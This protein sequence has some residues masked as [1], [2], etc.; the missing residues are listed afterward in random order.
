MTQGY[1][2]NN[3][4]C[5]R[6]EVFLR[7]VH[8]LKS[9]FEYVICKDK[10]Q[11]MFVK[12]TNSHVFFYYY[13]IMFFLLLY[14]FFLLLYMFFLLLLYHIFLITCSQGVI[15]LTINLPD[16]EQQQKAMFFIFICCV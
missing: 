11:I 2:N 12:Q 14:M 7:Y 16:S 3:I 15:P 13:I 10:L 8:L 4:T 1:W 9:R 5:I 6:I